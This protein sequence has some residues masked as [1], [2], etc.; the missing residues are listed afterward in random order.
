MKKLP[1]GVSDF[2][3]ILNDC[4]YYVDKTLLIKELIESS[5]LVILIPRPRRFGKTLNLSMLKYF[6]EK[7]DEDN[8]VLFKD[9]AIWQNRDY[10][11]FQGQ[12][13]VIFLTFKDIKEENWEITY[14]K[15]VSLVAQ[16]FSHHFDAIEKVILSSEI[17]EYIAIM[18]KKAD[19]ATYHNSLF[20]LSRLLYR[21]YNKKVVILIDEYDACIHA[22][23]NNNY[24]NTA[25]HFMRS[26]LTSVLKDNKYLE[27]GILTGILRTAKE[28]I[29]SGLN[30]LKVCSLLDYSFQDKF[31]FTQPEVENLLTHYNLLESFEDVQKWYNGYIVGNATIY[32]P[33]SLLMYADQK[34]KLQPYWLNTSDNQIIK[35]LL[36]LADAQ[37]KA[38]L[39]LLLSNG[40]VTKVVDEA[41]V[42]SDIENNS[43]A[44]WSLLLFAGYL[45][46]SKYVLERGKIYCDLKIPNEEI[47]F[48]YE[49]F[50]EDIFN[51]TLKTAKVDLFL[52]SL[53]T[54]DVQTFSELLQEFI[55]NSMS[56]YDL[57]ND[58]PEKSYHLFVLGLLV[59]LA[60]SYQI[61]S[62]RESGYGRYDIMLIP[63]DKNKLGLVI[64][65]KKVLIDR[66]ETLDSA[67]EK[68][69][70]QIRNKHYAQ[71]L[72]SLGIR[73]IKALG[74]AFQ[75]KQILVVSKDII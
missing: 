25:T 11:K 27:R 62:N 49:G 12:Y 64:E 61:K 28:G 36:V 60:D 40:T 29:F 38:D 75:G 17:N 14:I 63:H 41:I 5:G 47:K 26:V 18:G 24:Y 42:F 57:P 3:T 54:G 65:F 72:K 6:F 1:I 59:F 50:I 71:E 74:I 7:T 70:E 4:Y 68:A 19:E 37:L 10:R 31:G 20:F 16:A 52:N 67:A 8:S 39:E 46:Y 15:I 22:G 30:N 43:D 48:L 34:G 45:T 9:T 66:K 23:Y 33:W 69:L 21:A 2:K 58:E 73:R 53:I 51:R 55:L 44:I 13:P 35:K 32:N 56:I